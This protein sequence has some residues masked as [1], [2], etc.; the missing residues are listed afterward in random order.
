M[1]KSMTRRK[2]L[3]KKSITRKK[4]LRKKFMT[5]RKSL[6]KKFKDGME[7]KIS[8]LEKRQES[9]RKT[10][11]EEDFDKL[12][13]EINKYKADSDPEPTTNIHMLLSKIKR[14]GN[15]ELEEKI[16]KKFSLIWYT[17]VPR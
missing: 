3:R 7:K 16:T 10:I 14:N 8:E 5:R 12:I 9:L 13:E 4:S 11:K 1:K 17:V 15:I 2:S 6:R